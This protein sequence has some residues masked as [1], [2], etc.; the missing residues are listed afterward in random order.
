VTPCRVQL[1]TGT[2]RVPGGLDDGRWARELTLSGGSPPLPV[3]CAA[4][5]TP[6]ELAEVIVAI[7]QTVRPRAYE[8]YISTPEQA[9]AGRQ[10]LGAGAIGIACQR[11]RPGE[12]L[13]TLT[14]NIDR[15]PQPAPRAHRPAASRVPRRSRGPGS[16]QRGQQSPN[17]WSAAGHSALQR[18]VICRAERVA[19]TN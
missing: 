6:H 12:L 4:G 11:H 18:F 9:A 5:P 7:I 15:H 14:A 2:V 16:S 17:A 8:T 13:Y 1:F 19:I 3:G 10:H